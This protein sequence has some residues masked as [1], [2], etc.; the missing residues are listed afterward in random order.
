MRCVT[1]VHAHGKNLWHDA[2]MQ[3]PRR[4]LLV[5]DSPG[6]ARLVNELLRESCG[7]QH[8]VVLV[9]R[10][11]G[12]LA[13][14]QDRRFDAVLL[15]LSLPDSAG[16]D[17]LVRFREQAPEVPVVI[18]TG[19]NDEA[20]AIKAVQNGAQDY[21]VKGQGDGHLIRRAVGYAIERFRLE[22]EQHR[23]AGQLQDALMETIKALSQTVE[24]RD[25]FVAGHQYRVAVLARAIAETLGLPP[26]S[27]QGLY[28]AGLV[29]DM[30]K[31][32]IP[33]E[34]LNRPRPLSEEERGLVRTHPTASSDI[35]AEI[36]LPWPVARII[37][38]HHERLDG[39]GY[40]RGLKG[41]DLLPESRILAIADVVEAMSH[42]RAYR[43]AA[44]L[45]DALAEL[46]QGAGRLY[47]PD[48][49][50]ACLS[51]FREQGF[52]FPGGSDRL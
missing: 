39:S 52:T 24:R 47:D 16:L 4:L 32:H 5:E 27:R 10:L 40:P 46:E 13:V 45:E 34:I 35:L 18:L 15:D 11:A 36:D 9:D 17:T 38:E 51:L 23:S 25:P 3:T 12:A 31:L 37:A 33:S 22:R 49:V 43:P 8:H 26:H 44:R 1:F 20:I 19:L 42:S 28:L 50:Q 29:H 2:G 41:D 7:S 6:D 21:L 14:L 48:A 30:G